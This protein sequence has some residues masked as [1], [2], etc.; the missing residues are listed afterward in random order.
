[1][2]QRIKVIQNIVCEHSVNKLVTHE[3]GKTNRRGSNIQN[4]ARHL[5]KAML[6]FYWTSLVS[7]NANLRQ[8]YHETMRK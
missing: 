5:D 2:F 4:L 8:G 6:F 7:L 1:M 3:K